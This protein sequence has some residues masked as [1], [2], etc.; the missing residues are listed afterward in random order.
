[1]KHISIALT[2]FNRFD[3]LLQSIEQV[4]H[5]PRISEIVI[6]DDA[7]TDGS[8]IK[9]KQYFSDNE[10][11]KLFRNEQNLD[12]YRNKAQAVRGCQNEWVVLFD[13][14][15]ILG[16]D[17]IDRLYQLGDW[18]PAVVYC[19]DFAHPSFNYTAFSGLTVTKMNVA[20]FM[21]KPHFA[22]ALNTAN[23]F[24]NKSTYLQVW[25]GSVDPHTADTIYQALNLL[26][27]GF[28]LYLVPGLKYYH[29]IH[30]GSHYKQN[31]H[32]TGGFAKTV[33]DA[34]KA[35]R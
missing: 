9:L 35:L 10:K 19:P 34:I 1:M 27:N 32:K 33:E 28:Q 3:F 4:K 12:C 22:C 18:D 5:D 26:R 17:Y 29:R 2:H 16:P 11:V 13:S 21:D 7:S 8:F 24:V 6:S 14:D 31:V 20:R 25:D 15:N 23:Y 30:L